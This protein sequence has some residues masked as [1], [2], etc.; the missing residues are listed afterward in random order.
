MSCPLAFMPVSYLL[1]QR[2]TYICIAKPNE[3][4]K[5]FFLFKILIFK[6]IF[7]YKPKCL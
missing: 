3:P 5:R 6:P 2:D 7:I 1:F 4:L